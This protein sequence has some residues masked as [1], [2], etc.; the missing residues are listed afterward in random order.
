MSK[1]RIHS[2]ECKARVA[3]E[4]ISGRKMI[5]EFPADLAMEI[6]F[7]TQLPLLLIQLSY[8]QRQLLD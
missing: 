1:R 4:A 5:Q 2:S 3:M 8:W 6:P 7:A